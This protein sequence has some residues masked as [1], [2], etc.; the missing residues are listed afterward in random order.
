MEE[1]E[2]IS[3]TFDDLQSQNT[4]LLQ[5]LAERDDLSNQLVTERIK[6]GHAA[7]QHKQQQATSAAAVQRAERQAAVLQEQVANLQSKLQVCVRDFSCSQG[8]SLVI[9]DLAQH[10]WYIGNVSAVYRPSDLCWD[11]DLCACVSG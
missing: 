3:S 10:A 11:T 9:R 4:R 1:I 5:Q 2:V 6:S 7:A 8:H